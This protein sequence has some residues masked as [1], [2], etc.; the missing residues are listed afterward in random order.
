MA[1]R[2]IMIWNVCQTAGRLDFSWG[3]FRLRATVSPFRHERR[4]L[5]FVA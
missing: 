5:A 3:L 2:S 4:L 1:R